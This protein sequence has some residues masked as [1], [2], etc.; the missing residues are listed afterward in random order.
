M[1][2]CDACNETAQQAKIMREPKV[3]SATMLDG[4]GHALLFRV[5][6]WPGIHGCLTTLCAHSSNKSQKARFVGL[7]KAQPWALSCKGNVHGKLHKLTTG[8]L[9]KLGSPCIPPYTSTDVVKEGHRKG[10]HNL[11]ISPLELQEGAAKTGWILSN[12]K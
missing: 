11:E 10:T 8:L 7:L 4:C 6:N 12:A 5:S 3:H 2:H 9:S 1:R